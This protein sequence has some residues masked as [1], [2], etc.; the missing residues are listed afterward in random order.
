M[1]RVVAVLWL[2]CL[3][4]LDIIDLD[5]K[6][7]LAKRH[8]VISPYDWRTNVDRWLDYLTWDALPAEVKIRQQTETKLQKL[9]LTLKTLKIEFETKI[10]ER[11]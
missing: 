6:L 9:W 11:W 10:P 2:F 7:H 4:V 1:S 5:G 8:S 3:T